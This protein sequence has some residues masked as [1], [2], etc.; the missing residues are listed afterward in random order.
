MSGIPGLPTRKK[1]NERWLMS[2]ADLFTLLFGLFAMISATAQGGGDGFKR[3]A[4]EMAKSF[5]KAEGPTFNEDG[6]K[7]LD[8]KNRVVEKLAAAPT[9]NGGDGADNDTAKKLN[10]TAAAADP[11]NFGL[12]VEEINQSIV[13]SPELSKLAGSLIFDVTATGLRI[14]VVDQNSE[15]I[16]APGSATLLPRSTQLLT[17]I[18]HVIAKLPNYIDIEGHTDSSTST[19]SMGYT[20][21]EL[22]SDRA[23]A[24]RRVLIQG[25]VK[26]KQINK[27][28]GRADRELRDLEKPRSPGNRRITLIL[29][30]GYS[31]DES[32]FERL[33]K[34]LHKN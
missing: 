9:E 30:R 19:D 5:N 26:D 7:T 25:N 6:V 3:Q 13:G 1:K 24:A 16:F 8:K 15:N 34:F 2:L 18:A 21:W 27:V 17:Q 12:A 22:S 14:Q 31:L 23:L 11:M 4:G 20:N 29:E 10:S 33:P 32:S 28:S